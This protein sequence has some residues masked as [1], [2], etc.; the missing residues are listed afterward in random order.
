MSVHIFNFIFNWSDLILIK[1]ENLKKCEELKLDF[2]GKMNPSDMKF[3]QNLR[4]K[5]EFNIDHSK[6]QEY[7]P[8]HVVISGIFKIYQVNCLF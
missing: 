7:F 6:L 3:Y 4:E 2:D 5:K 8:L 1:F